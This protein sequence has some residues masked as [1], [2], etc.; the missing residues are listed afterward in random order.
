M[1]SSL[2]GRRHRG[3][4]KRLSETGLESARL[5][6]GENGSPPCPGSGMNPCGRRVLEQRPLVNKAVGDVYD[7]GAIVYP[8][9]S[10]VDARTV[11]KRRGRLLLAGPL[12][13]G[14]L[15]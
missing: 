3:G 7:A 4:W 5:E 14:G 15:L 10:M 2:D 12:Q 8:R 9:W 1:S 11:Q 13:S 6:S